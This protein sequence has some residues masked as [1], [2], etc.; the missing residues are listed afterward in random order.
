[1]AFPDNERRRPEIW[2]FINAEPVGI[3]SFLR[4]E[5]GV[6]LRASEELAYCPEGSKHYSAKSGNFSK[7][8]GIYQNE[9]GYTFRG[10]EGD[11]QA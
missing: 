2:Q 11:L 4:Q 8:G 10:S 9:L 3:L 5:F 7:S 1:M 6:W